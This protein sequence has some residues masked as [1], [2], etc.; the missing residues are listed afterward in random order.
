MSLE[1]HILRW[2][3]LFQGRIH[4]DVSHLAY[5]TTSQMREQGRPGRGNGIGMGLHDG[6]IRHDNDLH[7]GNGLGCGGYD[8]QGGG[9]SM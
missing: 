1:K 9:N 5:R 4:T 7:P 3:L 8:K 6:G 2:P